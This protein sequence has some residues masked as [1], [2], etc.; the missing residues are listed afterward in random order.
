[1]FLFTNILFSEE[2]AKNFLKSMKRSILQFIFVLP[3]LGLL[4][5]IYFKLELPVLYKFGLKKNNM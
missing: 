2:K 3:L 4:N 5:L 1:M